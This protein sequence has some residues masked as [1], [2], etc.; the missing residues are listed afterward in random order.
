MSDPLFP[1]HNITDTQS[2]PRTIV[3]GRRV[4]SAGETLRLTQQEYNE[5]APMLT[6]YV[7]EKLLCEGQLP[8]EVVLA[9][10]NRKGKRP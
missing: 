3:L 7:R 6:A 8:T 1:V 5:F 2:V 9:R 4:L 10:R